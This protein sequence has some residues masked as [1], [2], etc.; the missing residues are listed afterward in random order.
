MLSTW[1][2]AAAA[3]YV[4]T[5]VSLYTTPVQCTKILCDRSNGPVMFKTAGTHFDVGCVKMQTHHDVAVAVA[6]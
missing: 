2:A 1:A 3:A 6:S 5:C 4:A